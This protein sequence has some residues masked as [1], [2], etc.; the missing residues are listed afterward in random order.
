[1]DRQPPKWLLL[2]LIAVVG[3]VW[4]W[5]RSQPE[6]QQRLSCAFLQRAG[7]AP[8]KTPSGKAV[9]RRLWLQGSLERTTQA[10][11]FGFE[12]STIAGRG[13][14]LTTGSVWLDKTGDVDG[15][16]VWASHGDFGSKNLSIATLNGDGHL[17]RDPST[18]Y[19]FINPP[20]KLLH[21]ADYI[22]RVTEV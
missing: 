17:D 20:E 13:K 3:G 9:P 6:P 22:C 11:M 10:G 5:Q 14:A 2:V 7:S 4:L 21:V 19:L 18:A 12:G 1:M 15:I 16:A 8:I